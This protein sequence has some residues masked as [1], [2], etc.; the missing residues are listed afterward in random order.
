MQFPI[1][2]EDLALV[3]PAHAVAC[4]LRNGVGEFSSVCDS[5]VVVESQLV[6][7]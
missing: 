5:L 2:V 1:S 6:K 3:E 4:S 7:L